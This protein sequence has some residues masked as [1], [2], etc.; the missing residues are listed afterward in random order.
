M[1]PARPLGFAATASTVDLTTVAPVLQTHDRLWSH[2]RNWWLLDMTML[3]TLGLVM[4]GFVRWR[5]RLRHR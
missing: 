5:V 3:A 2:A 4:A 1:A